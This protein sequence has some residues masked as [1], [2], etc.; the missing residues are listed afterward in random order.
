MQDFVPV[1]IGYL[2]YR[3]LEFIN[4]VPLNLETRHI[5]FVC[6]KI[7]I[8]NVIMPIITIVS[9]IFQL[10]LCSKLMLIMHTYDLF[11]RLSQPLLTIQVKV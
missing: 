2:H 5:L 7:I 3:I 6:M 1:S 11:I 9:K 4:A 10:A 8:Y